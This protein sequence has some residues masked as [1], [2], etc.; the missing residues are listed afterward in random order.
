MA[1]ISLLFGSYVSIP[2]I[3]LH[4]LRMV[5]FCSKVFFVFVQKTKTLSFDYKERH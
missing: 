2:F 1:I 3:S 5:T 4:F